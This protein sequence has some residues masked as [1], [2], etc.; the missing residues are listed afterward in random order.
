ML[1]AINLLMSLSGHPVD[2]GGWSIHFCVPGGYPT[3]ARSGHPVEHR[4]GYGLRRTH[5]GQVEPYFISKHADGWTV[6]L[7][8]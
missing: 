5:D 2:G 4:M 6:T 8:E 7:L 3:G 1:T